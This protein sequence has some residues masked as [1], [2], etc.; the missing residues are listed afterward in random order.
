MAISFAQVNTPARTAVVGDRVMVVTD[1][2]A[3]S[4]YPTGGYALS[5]AT[6]G[7]DSIDYVD[8]QFNPV[9][10][11]G[12]GGYNY[13]TGKL[14]LFTALSGTEVTNTTDVH[15]VTGRLQVQGKGR[16]SFSNP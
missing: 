11:A 12:L 5:P 16:A 2:T 7:L 1:F 3:D 8:I 14:Q 6:F 9:A 4:S 15:T 13:A 10:A